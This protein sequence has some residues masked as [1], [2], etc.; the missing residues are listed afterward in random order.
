M[1][2][3]KKYFA[4]LFVIIA[5]ISC[6]QVMDLSPEEKTEITYDKI[7]LSLFESGEIN[8]DVD[9]SDYTYTLMISKTHCE[10]SAIARIEVVSA[11]EFGGEFVQLPAE[12]YEIATTVDFKEN[13]VLQMLE[14]RIKDIN[15]LDASQK[16]V[17][18]LR[19]VSDDINVDDEKNLLVFYL[20]PKQG[21]I[22]SPYIITTADELLQLQSYLADGKNTYVRL[23]AD[24]DMT[25]K[26]W[27]PVETSDFR[28]IDFDGCGHTISNLNVTSS[29]SAYQ[30]FFGAL[31]GRCANVTFRDAQITADR[32]LTGIVAGS[33][34]LRGTSPVATGEV[35]NVHVSGDISLVSDNGPQGAWDNGQAGGICGLLHGASV[36]KACSSTVDLNVYWSAGGIAGEARRGALIEECWFVGTVT[37]KSCAG[38]I[39]SRLLGAEIRN[40]YSK[41]TISALPYVVANP[42]GGIAGWVQPNFEDATAATISYCWSSCSV[43]AQNQVGGIMGNAN[44]TTG[45]GITVHHCV[46]WNT[47]L[48]SGAAPKSGRVCGRY[49]K[50]VAYSCYAN[51][52]MA[53]AI[54]GNPAITDQSS[55]NTGNGD[56][57][58]FDRYNGLSD[59]ETLM[60]AVEALSWDTQIWD[61]SG[62][63]PRLK[64]ETATITNI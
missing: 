59:K 60:V 32:K 43:A 10:K 62:T 37:T 14:L 28:T 36:I 13:D 52:N 42:A 41:G 7:S 50:N 35:Y 49:S 25:G 27:V 39:A 57:G 54:K 53:M 45:N 34:G 9:Q 23:G 56:T 55:V 19:L 33:V 29:T 5:L 18:G 1:D 31:V 38:G 15:T 40:C 63:E 46:A 6:D 48:T 11:E 16:Y 3:M 51:P 20:K 64:W 44:N 47:D 22:D 30:G 17:L 2:V 12:H 26:V 21:G 61:L 58:T 4:W 24:I 8:V